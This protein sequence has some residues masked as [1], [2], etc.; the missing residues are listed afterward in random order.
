VPQH[1]AEQRDFRSSPRASRPTRARRWFTE[2]LE[3]VAALL[4]R[5]AV[6]VTH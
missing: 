2:P 5:A 1:A 4:G 6:A 3:R